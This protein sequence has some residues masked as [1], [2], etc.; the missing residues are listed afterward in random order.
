[1][2]F[3]WRARNIHRALN[4]IEPGRSIET[5]LGHVFVQRSEVRS[6]IQKIKGYLRHEEDFSKILITGHKGAGKT[7]ELKSFASDG[8]IKRRFHVGFVSGSDTGASAIKIISAILKQIKVFAQ[9]EGFAEEVAGIDLLL[10]HS[11]GWEPTLEVSGP[12]PKEKVDKNIFGPAGDNSEYTLKFSR[13]K[14]GQ[15]AGPG[16]VI[17]SISDAVD[18]IVAKYRFFRKKVLIII[19]DVDGF[20]LDDALKLLRDEIGLVMKA[21]CYAIITCPLSLTYHENWGL[22][23]EQFAGVYHVTPFEPFPLPEQDGMFSI[24][25]I[26]HE[27]INIRLRHRTHYDDKISNGVNEIQRQMIRLKI[28]QLTDEIDN[29]KHLLLEYN[30]HSPGAL[31]HHFE[32]Y[33]F[34]EAQLRERLHITTSKK[35]RQHILKK[36]K[37]LEREKNVLRQAIDNYENLNRI[38]LMRRQLGIHRDVQSHVEILLKRESSPKLLQRL[39]RQNRRLNDDISVLEQRVADYEA[40]Y[41]II[42]KRIHE[43]VFESPA[44]IDDIIIYS[45]GVPSEMLRLI[46]HCCVLYTNT[47]RWWESWIW[48]YGKITRE[49]L[50]EVIERIQRTYKRVLTD[51]RIFV[52]QHIRA[53]QDY[54]EP[55][56]EDFLF[57]VREGLIIQYGK[58]KDVDRWFGI[59]PLVE[60]LLPG[61]DIEKTGGDGNVQSG[62]DE[63]GDGDIQSEG[64]GPD[65]GDDQ[66]GGTAELAEPNDEKIAAESDTENE[67]DLQ[68]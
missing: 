55:L 48:F 47:H 39:Q 59:H 31:K 7:T 2:K 12:F 16:D 49:L 61:L 63:P 66:S 34:D 29:L 42:T 33:N 50:G 10:S 41:G 36:M 65:N 21:K 64:D 6:D 35:E 38:D 45:G 23:K 25:K 13:K 4:I 11:L 46:R 56:D 5:I 62:D 37:Q 27:Q 67:D 14:D 26:L 43:R 51:E 22:I 52:L 58:E 44:L 54:D 15:L 9:K 60:E 20:S 53:N 19:T 18:K 17:K 1:M 57:L 32:K 8:W 24:D 30:F 68:N 28:R 3:F 40:L